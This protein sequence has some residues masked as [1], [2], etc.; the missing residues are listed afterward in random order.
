MNAKLK[1]WLAAHPGLGR[2]DLLNVNRLLDRAY[3]RPCAI[4]RRRTACSHRE[5]EVE[6]A[7]LKVRPQ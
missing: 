7:L 3:R 2:V 5:P 6:F 1:A 4:C